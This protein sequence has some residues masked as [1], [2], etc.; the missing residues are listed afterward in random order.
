MNKIHEI[1][2]NEI[3]KQVDKKKINPEK[4]F[5]LIVKTINEATEEEVKTILIGYLVMEV[6]MEFLK[7]IHEYEQ[8]TKKYNG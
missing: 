5:D 4:I 3:Q 6:N 8:L 7:P 2:A 1:I